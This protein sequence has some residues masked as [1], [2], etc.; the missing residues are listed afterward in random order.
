MAAGFSD[1]YFYL[2][3]VLL[4]IDKQLD[5]SADALSIYEVLK[6]VAGIPLFF[7]DHYQRLQNSL[8]LAEIKDFMVSSDLIKN[9]VKALC[10]AN[11]KF[12][13]NMELRVSWLKGNLSYRIG[14]IPHSYPEPFDYLYGVSV[15][16]LVSQRENPN[17]K[18]KHSTTRQQ[19]NI[20]LKEH[21]LYEVLL[22]NNE[23]QITEGSRSNVFFIKREQVFTAPGTNV[24]KGITRQYVL[25]ALQHLQI[26]LHE[27][28][29]TLDLL[30][31]FDA[32]FLCGTSPGVLPIK[33]IENIAFDANNPLLR[34]II[35]VF[36][37]YA[38]DYLSANS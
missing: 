29:V 10:T 1:T 25:K 23:N 37:D 18:I 4:A 13:G 36:N 32:A 15:G 3:N 20:Y 7:E 30:P 16:T 8:Q 5:E 12:F 28:L 26:E 21:E 33:S 24:L 22:I 27:T 35:K 19:A 31:E 38:Q 2:N 6:I 9:Q 14:F 34:K 17:A 11:N